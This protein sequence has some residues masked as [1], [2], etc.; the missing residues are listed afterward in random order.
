M[1]PS[2]EQQ[3]PLSPPAGIVPTASKTIKFVRIFLLVLIIIGVGLIATQSLWVPK[4]V[5]V[6]LGNQMPPVLPVTTTSAPVWTVCTDDSCAQTTKVA[7]DTLSAIPPGEYLNTE[8]MR[9]SNAIYYW[10]DHNALGTNTLIDL[11]ADPNTFVTFPVINETYGKDKNTVWYGDT[12]V[13][14]ADSSTFTAEDLYGHDATHAYYIGEIIPGADPSTYE[15]LSGAYSKD[16]VRVYFATSTIVGADA[17]SFQMISDYEF[18]K[19]KNHV[20]SWGVIMPGVD[21]ATYVPPPPG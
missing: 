10:D 17:S 7:Q 18:A 13:Q 20:Y 12:V 15:G 1:P 19:D 4:L 21:P 9:G 11:H 2:P 5:D 8:Y 3:N 6:I 14:G 16:A